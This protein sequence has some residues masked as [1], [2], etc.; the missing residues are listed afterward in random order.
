MPTG[1][2]A[3]NRKSD[4]TDGGLYPRKRFSPARGTMS[5]D[6]HGCDR[7]PNGG[8]KP[9]AGQTSLRRQAAHRFTLRRLQIPAALP[10][11]KN[12]RNTGILYPPP[13]T[14]HRD[15]FRPGSELNILP[16]SGVAG[17]MVQRHRRR[18]IPGI[19]GIQGLCARIPWSFWRRTCSQM[20]YGA[21]RHVVP[22][23]M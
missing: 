4:G 8:M 7:K 22:A 12:R 11:S 16:A 21:L 6:P 1:D 9:D 2:H 19:D 13:A 18:R 3:Q 15:F 17:A 20:D 14:R 23:R 10:R 5:Y